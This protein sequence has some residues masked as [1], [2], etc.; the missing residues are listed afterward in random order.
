MK[1]ILVFALL[2]SITS[3]VQAQLKPNDEFH[4]NLNIQNKVDSIAVFRVSNF[5]PLTYAK[6]AGELIDGMELELSS[7]GAQIDV[8][9]P[10]VIENFQFKGETE[11][12]SVLKMN[13][14]KSE[15]VDAQK[16]FLYD[17]KNS[18]R[19]SYFYYFPDQKG[20]LYRKVSKSK[21]SDYVVYYL[22]KKS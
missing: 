8:Y 22:S 14:G 13:N 4:K 12:M 2:V 9:S 18:N 21:K 15:I 6:V 1:R 19:K 11:E 20:L 3:L 7:R 10:G 16:V 5:A 17:D